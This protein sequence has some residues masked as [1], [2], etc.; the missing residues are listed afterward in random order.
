MGNK[1]GI[2]GND[3]IG[4]GKYPEIYEVFSG[5]IC[6]FLE[7]EKAETTKVKAKK[8]MKKRPYEAR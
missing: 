7:E 8:C 2:M 3:W 4:I 1:L 6:S 5:P